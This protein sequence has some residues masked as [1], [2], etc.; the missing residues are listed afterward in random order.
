LDTVDLLRDAVTQVL[1]S[2]SG[3][4]VI[5]LGEVSYID[6]A[7]LGVLVGTYNRLSDEQRSLSIRCANPQVFRLFEIT[8]LTDLLNVD[9][10]ARQPR[11]SAQETSRPVSV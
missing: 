2:R 7:G 11:A 8:G 10:T 3:D 1:H 6:S 9:L 4:L 5:D